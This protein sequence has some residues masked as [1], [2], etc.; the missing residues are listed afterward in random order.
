M[1]LRLCPGRGICSR[2]WALSRG[3]GSCQPSPRHFLL[4]ADPDGRVPATFPGRRRWDDGAEIP[5]SG[6]PGAACRAGAGPGDR[7][8]RGADLPDHVLRLPRHRPRRRP[9]QPRACRATSTAGSPT[10][11]WP[12]SRS[13]WPRWR[14]GSAAVATASGQAALHLAIATLMGAGSHIVAARNLY[15]GS[16]NLLRLT[17]PRF[18]IETTFVD[19]RDPTAFAAA[20]RPETRLVLAE[21]VGNPGPR[22]AGPPGR[23]GD[24][25]RARAAAAGRQHLH[26]ALAVPA[27]RARRRPRRP[28]ADQVAGRPRRRHRRRSWSTA[29]AST[30]RPRA[31]SR[32]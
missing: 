5:R 9:V 10:R 30:G 15:G 11:P 13:G 16:V 25:A 18:G 4:P 19:P 8:A 20:I 12:C 28:F 27:D 14:A 6:N 17:L 31:A 24:R 32:P 26:H 21:V 23:G 1:F 22:G 2:A 3:E 7:R 29:A